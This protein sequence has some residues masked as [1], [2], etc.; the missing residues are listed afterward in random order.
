M[1]GVVSPLNSTLSGL[2]LPVKAK[3]K[4]KSNE[5]GTKMKVASFPYFLIRFEEEFEPP[6]YSY[7]PITKAKETYPNDELYLI[8]G[9]DTMRKL[10]NWKNFDTHIKD[11]IGFIEL[12]RGETKAFKATKH[13]LGDDKLFRKWLDWSDRFGEESNSLKLQIQRIDISSTIVRNMVAEGMNPYPYVTE[14]VYKIIAEN[15]L[16]I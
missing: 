3:S 6:V 12:S 9:E 13:S 16:Y 4:Y 5:S 7:L 8:G 1:F 11:K 10:P 14:D 2:L 15:K